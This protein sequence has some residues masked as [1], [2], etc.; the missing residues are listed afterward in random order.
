MYLINPLGKVKGYLKAGMTYNLSITKN[1]AV[2]TE[3]SGAKD[4]IE[5]GNVP[6][7]TPASGNQAVTSLKSGYLSFGV[8]QEL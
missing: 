2:R 6:F 7:K 3:Y 5:N 4:G 1:P 8:W